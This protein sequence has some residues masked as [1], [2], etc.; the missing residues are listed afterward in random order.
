LD[1]DCPSCLRGISI[2]FTATF[3]GEVS[4][5]QE[6]ISLIQ[7]RGNESVGFITGKVSDYVSQ[8]TGFRVGSH[9][10]ITAY[11][12]MEFKLGKNYFHTR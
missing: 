7:E 1:F 11:H 12:V 8:G 5:T 9:Y 10:L 3:A 2:F 6:T 4:M